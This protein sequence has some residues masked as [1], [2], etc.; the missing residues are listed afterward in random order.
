MTPL[1]I[2]LRY[3]HPHP[4]GSWQFAYKKLWL[5]GDGQQVYRYI[6]CACTLV[7]ILHQSTFDRKVITCVMSVDDYGVVWW[8]KGVMDKWNLLYLVM[9]TVLTD[10]FGFWDHYTNQHKMSVH[11]HHHIYET[12]WER[13]KKTT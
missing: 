1:I 3:D 10:V 4:S 11:K 9:I 8:W 6:V 2:G 12:S 7:V 5:L 13:K